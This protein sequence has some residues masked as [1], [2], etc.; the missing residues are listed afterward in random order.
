MGF[1]VPLTVV[2]PFSRGG[3]V[4]SD[5]FDHTSQMRFLEERFGVKAPNIS[6][7]R[8]KNS[9]DLTTSLQVTRSP[10]VSVP[11][12]PATD[13]RSALVRAQCTLGQLIEV[14]LNNPAPYPL[15]STQSL[16]SQ[17]AGSARRV[18]T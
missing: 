18:K 13:A 15:P 2:S 4:C 8:R 14:D 3:Y 10:D 6:E 7:W 5:V 12:L 9:G 16:P 17:E 1:R 11:T